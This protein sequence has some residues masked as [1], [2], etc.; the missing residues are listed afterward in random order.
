VLSRSFFPGRKT[1]RPSSRRFRVEEV[2][3]GCETNAL[4][5]NR[6]SGFFVIAIGKVFSSRDD[7]RQDDRANALVRQYQA[8]LDSIVESHPELQLQR[9]LVACKQCAIRFLTDPRNAG[10]TDLRCPF[11]CRKRAHRQAANRRS[12]AHY[13]TPLGRETKERLNRRRYRRTPSAGDQEQSVL[14]PQAI[15]RPE[16]GTDERQRKVELRLEGVVLD[17]SSVVNSP[18]LPYLRMVVR[19]I[20]GIPLT[21]RELVRLL[22]QALRQRSLAF[23]NRI[24]YVLCFLHQHPP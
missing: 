9:C 21:C 23:R 4:Y 2:G 17:E 13:R 8:A 19:L 1:P 24:D 12:T 15:S 6:E 20:E 18:M 16:P 10:R 5:C 7:W 11:G 14:D 3:R 22:R